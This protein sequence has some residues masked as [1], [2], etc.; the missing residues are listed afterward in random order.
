M[1]IINPTCRIDDFLRVST[2]GARLD[3]S[4]NFR[5]DSEPTL[6]TAST[7]LTKSFWG[8]PENVLFYQISRPLKWLGLETNMNGKN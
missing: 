1:K 4:E 7:S 2:I 3:G 6:A 8:N 5:G